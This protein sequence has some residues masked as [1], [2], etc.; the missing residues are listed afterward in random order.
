M[1]PIYMQL[2]RWDARAWV[3]NGIQEEGTHKTG[4]IHEKS[5]CY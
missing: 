2:P 1:Q 3:K 5:I 4:V